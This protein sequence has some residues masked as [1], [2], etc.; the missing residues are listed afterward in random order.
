MMY[1]TVIWLFI[2]SLSIRLRGV[3]TMDRICVDIC[4]NIVNIKQAICGDCKWCIKG[5]II[6]TCECR[7]WNKK[8]RIDSRPCEWFERG[9][10]K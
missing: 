1:Q 5:N 3:I 6:V 7:Y 2:S 4:D 9:E 8:L 10:Y